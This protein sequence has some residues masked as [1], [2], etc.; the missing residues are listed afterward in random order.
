M[1][2]CTRL[3]PPRASTNSLR[4]PAGRRGP[5]PPHPLPFPPPPPKPTV[6]A[7]TRRPPRDLPA[8]RFRRHCDAPAVAAVSEQVNDPAAQ[9]LPEI[10]HPQSSPPRADCGPKAAAP[11]TSGASPAENQRIRGV[12]RATLAAVPPPRS[13]AVD[14]LE[15]TPEKAGARDTDQSPQKARR[16]DGRETTAVR[17]ILRDKLFH[18]FAHEWI[19][20]SPHVGTGWNEEVHRPFRGVPGGII[21]HL[22]WH[23]VSQISL[24]QMTKCPTR[25]ALRVLEITPAPRGGSVVCSIQQ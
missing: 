15:S 22:L 7:G 17:K 2:Q 19:R 23:G 25:G 14:P 21:G 1:P 13:R 11:P 24:G 20:T 6:C 8:R 10:P 12:E 16:P 9:F 18:C 5:S 4:A 3:V